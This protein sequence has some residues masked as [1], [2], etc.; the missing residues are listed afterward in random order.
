M[1]VAPVAL[2]AY[3]FCRKHFQHVPGV[4]AVLF[5]PHALHKLTP[6]RY[7]AAAIYIIWDGLVKADYPFR[8][9]KAS[10]APQCRLR[11]GWDNAED[12]RRAAWSAGAYLPLLC[13]PS[14]VALP[15]L[16]LPPC[17]AY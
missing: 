12:R 11:L 16:L 15:C 6:C 1:S 9:S 14:I 8:E 2:S 4:W 17:C 3:D 10:K 7:P 13:P 5:P